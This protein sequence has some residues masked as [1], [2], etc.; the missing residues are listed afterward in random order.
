[1]SK[2]LASIHAEEITSAQNFIRS[3]GYEYDNDDVKTRLISIIVHY[4]KGLLEQGEG[5]YILDEHFSEIFMLSPEQ[6][7]QLLILENIVCPYMAK[8]VA[9]DKIYALKEI[10]NTRLCKKSKESLSRKAVLYKDGKFDNW[11]FG[12]IYNKSPRGYSEAIIVGKDLRP[13]NNKNYDNTGVL[14]I[15]LEITKYL[16]NA[17]DFYE[18]ILKS[19][20]VPTMLIEFRP[21]DDLVVRVFGK[22]FD[23]STNIS[24]FFVKGQIAVIYLNGE[25][26]Y[27]NL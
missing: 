27:N 1:M 4:N 11:E 19:E 26:V 25:H 7:E 20:D 23:E 8:Y 17:V 9:R 13:V 14:S 10:I 24:M 6:L 5:V 21:D 16:K 15:P 22:A 18:R 3:N 12:N 2:T